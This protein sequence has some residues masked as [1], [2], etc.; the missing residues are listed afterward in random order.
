MDLVVLIDDENAQFDPALLVSQ[1]GEL[2][3]K[4]SCHHVGLSS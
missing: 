2:L 3:S 4:V 1:M